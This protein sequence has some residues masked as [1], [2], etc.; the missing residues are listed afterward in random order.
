[1][2]D[3]RIVSR[4]IELER[5][6]A[7]DAIP[8]KVLS[9]APIGGLLQVQIEP[10]RDRHN[11]PLDESLEG[12]RAWW[13]A[14]PPGS[15]DCLAVDSE[16]STITLRFVRGPAPAVGTVLMLYE[17]DFY[18][19]LAGLWTQPDLQRRANERMTSKPGMFTP[20][21]GGKVTKGVRLRRAQ[22]DALQ[23]A[24]QSIGLLH[25]PPGTGKT[26]TVGRLVA[27]Q[28]ALHSASILII[29]T[30]NTA[31]DQA[32]IAVDDALVAAGMTKTRTRCKRIGSRVEAKRYKGREHLLP[33]SDVVLFDKLV[34]TEGREPEKKD[35]VAWAVWKQEVDGLR[36][37]LKVRVEEIVTTNKVVAI[38]ATAATF[39]F[40]ALRAKDFDIIIVDEA[41]QMGGASALML[42]L[43]G[44]KVLF[45]GDPQQLAAVVRSPHPDPRKYLGTT[46]FAIFRAAPTVFLNEQSRMINEIS[47]VISKVFYGGK[48]IVAKDAEMDPDWRAHRRLPVIRGER[49]KPLRVDLVSTDSTWSQKYRGPIRYD[50]ADKIVSIIRDL[51]D[52]DVEL[53]DIVVLTPFRAQKTLLRYMLKANNMRGI[54]VSTVHRAQGSERKVVIFD[55]VDGSGT[56]LRGSEGDRL[57][58]VAVSRAKSQAILLLSKRD[59][60]NSTLDR[61]A[62]MAGAP[63]YEQIKVASYSAPC[64]SAFVKRSDFPAC[65]QKLTIRIADIVGTVVAIEKGGTQII[66]ETLSDQQR[67]KFSVAHLVKMA[68]A[69]A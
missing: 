26:T 3:G 17:P 62:R 31:V 6:V 30:T 13:P 11:R 69:A 54:S 42:S 23:L 64:I 65:L 32:L 63:G 37:K 14:T 58:N 9:I 51:T 19:A 45:A 43:L 8:F 44:R 46:A 4:A 53:E 7:R 56:F 29:A 21:K 16:T 41:S 28:L 25:G 38:T 61:I 33:V 20:S 57:I 59:R 24:D 47:E 10:V 1:M 34:A 2:W 67:R 40:E 60:E 49:Q 66:L 52:F 68:S 5:D 50:S 35:I 39:W 18:E 22:A 55:P 36:A 15:A 27:T 12:A 48:L